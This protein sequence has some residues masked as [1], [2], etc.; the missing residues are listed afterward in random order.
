MPLMPAKVKFRKSHRGVNR[1]VAQRGQN[2]SFGE[3]GL[4]AMEH[5]WLSNKVIEAARIAITRTMKRRGKVWIRIFPHKSYTKKPLETRMG[6]GKGPV[7]G[8]VAV[9]KPGAVMFELD[10][11]PFGTAQQAL[12]LAATK[13]PI[14]TKLIARHHSH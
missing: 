5:C 2:V 7:E 1:G 3:Y 11:V 9:I 10:G 14:R 8:W 6:K 12:R 13:M 4:Q